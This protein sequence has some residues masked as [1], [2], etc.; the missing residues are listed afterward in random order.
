MAPDAHV[1]LISRV[2]NGS[3]SGTFV[4]PRYG[5]AHINEGIVLRVRSVGVAGD[6]LL[7]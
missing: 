7:V 2:E 6:S 3:A 4:V 1:D 5:V